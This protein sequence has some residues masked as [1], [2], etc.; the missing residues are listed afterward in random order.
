MTMTMLLMLIIH[1]RGSQ[2]RLDHAG[3]VADKGE[4][5][6]VCRLSGNSSHDA[7]A[8]EGKVEGN[9]ANAWSKL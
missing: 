4:H 5:R 9:V 3:W 1:L 6:P 7:D 8:D 2:G